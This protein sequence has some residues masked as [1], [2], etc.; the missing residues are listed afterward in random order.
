MS[1]SVLVQ[2]V[3]KTQ[4]SNE[5]FVS[6]ISVSCLPPNTVAPKFER[7]PSLTSFQDRSVFVVL[8]G[9]SVEGSVLRVKDGCSLEKIVVSKLTRKTASIFS[10][11]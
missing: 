1:V 7:L 2:N 9:G 6:S 8:C 10:W 3:L 5:I 4:N 11:T